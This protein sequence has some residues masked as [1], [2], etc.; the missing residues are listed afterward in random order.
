L[1]VLAVF[2]W[3]M[4][5][6]AEGAEC[7]CGSSKLLAPTEYGRVAVGVTIM[8]LFFSAFDVA[9]ATVFDWRWNSSFVFVV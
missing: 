2:V 4:A 3:E 9:G 8:C 1:I 5:V 6:G 7:F